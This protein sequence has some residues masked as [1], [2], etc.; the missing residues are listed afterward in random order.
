MHSVARIWSITALTVTWCLWEFSKLNVCICICWLNRMSPMNMFHFV[1]SISNYK[2]MNQITYSLT[3]ITPNSLS[4]I[5]QTVV[6]V[7]LMMSASLRVGPWLVGMLIQPS[8][9]GGGFWVSLEMSTTSVAPKSTPRSSPI[10]MSS[11]TSSARWDGGAKPTTIW[12]IFFPLDV[13]FNYRKWTYAYR[14]GTILGSVLTTS[15]LLPSLPS[16]L[17]FECWP[18]GSFGYQQHNRQH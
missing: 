16:S 17:Q 18:P 8:S 7:W 4:L 12:S 6:S 10:S 9:C 3:Q 15:P 5:L 2:K 13:L 1:W 11:G 14:S